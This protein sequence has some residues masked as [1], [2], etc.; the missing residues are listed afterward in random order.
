MPQTPNKISDYASPYDAP[1][2]PAWPA[3]EIP[4]Y[5]QDYA[6]LYAQDP[7]CWASLL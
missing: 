2:L 5:L 4:T 7:N 1:A 3:I 6:D